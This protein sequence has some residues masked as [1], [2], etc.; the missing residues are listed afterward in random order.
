MAEPRLRASIAGASGYIGGELLRLLLDHPRIEVAQATSESNAGK[1][2]HGTHPNLRGRTQLKF[3]ALE[4]LEACEVLFLALPHGATQERIGQFEELA[5]RIVDLSA[6]FRLRT[7]AAY[8]AWYGKNHGCPARLGEFVYGLPEL[9][10][11]EL[12]GASKVSGVGCNATAVNLALLPLVSAGLVDQAKPIVVEIKVG[13]SEGGNKPRITSHHP[14]R[15]GTVRAFAPVGH[16]HTAEVEQE[17]GLGNVH[18]SVT[19]VEMV[20]GAVA[21]AHVW[22]NQAVSEQDLYRA[23]RSTYGAEPFVRVVRSPVGTFRYPEPKILAGSNYADVGFEL[24]ARSG[25][26]VAICALDNL[27]KG[28]A[29]SALQCF[30]LMMGWEESEGLGFPGLHPL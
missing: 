29:G 12:A 20:R 30:N 28:G 15:S 8:A 1:Y 18:L 10:R 2:V 16:R 17:L 7:G 11:K 26:V 21:T 3:S 13:S 24:D 6:D 5:P 14:E 23:W 19:A 25:R 22:P 27:M 9:H 4:D